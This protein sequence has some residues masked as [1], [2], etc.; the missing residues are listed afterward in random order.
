VERSDRVF[1][2]TSAAAAQADPHSPTPARKR[3]LGATP[4]VPGR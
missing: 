2:V 1:L 3:A 4:V